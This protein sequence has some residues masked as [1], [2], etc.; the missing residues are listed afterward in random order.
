MPSLSSC[1]C[2]EVLANIC[3]TGTITSDVQKYEGTPNSVLNPRPAPVCL[4]TIAPKIRKPKWEKMLPKAY[5]IVSAEE[6][7]N[8]LKLK[9][10][11]ET[12]NTAHKKSVTTL[13]DSG[14]TGEFIN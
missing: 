6:S 14:A 4:H 13:V 5:I 11:I 8:S 10:K 3:D 1:N 2:F 7:S 12:T 9:V